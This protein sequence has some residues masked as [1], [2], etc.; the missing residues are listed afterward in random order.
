M[1]M[2]KTVAIQ[3]AKAFVAVH[4]GAGFYASHNNSLFI[5]LCRSVCSE[6]LRT[7]ENG[8]S[9]VEAVCAAV[10]ALENNPLTNAGVGSNLTR[11]GTVECDASVMESSNNL[12]GACGAV[13]GVKN[14]VLLAREILH[15][16]MSPRDG[17]VAPMIFVGDGAVQFAKSQNVETVDLSFHQTEPRLKKYNEKKRS[18]HCVDTSTAS[19]APNDAESELDT[20]G[21]IVVDMHGVIAVASSSGGVAFKYSGRIGQAATYG[22]GIW[23]ETVGADG[24]AC[25]VSGTGEQIIQTSLAKAFCD[26]LQQDDVSLE[27]E[28]EL[29]AAIRVT[30]VHWCC[31]F[32]T[33]C[34]Q[35]KDF[36]MWFI[37]LRDSVGRWLAVTVKILRRNSVVFFFPGML[38]VPLMCKAWLCWDILY[39][40]KFLKTTI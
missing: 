27:S 17:L 6:V 35:P 16:Q 4:C 23:C 5:S 15:Q 24:F 26:A 1:G 38:P 18:L 11:D 3:S 20:V 32:Q 2:E 8:S 29:P 10:V 37:L 13:K 21:A 36:C 28:K 30:W 25:C 9:A 19:G 31:R 12:F 39:N 34:S 40:S 7:L 22:A 14:P 33:G